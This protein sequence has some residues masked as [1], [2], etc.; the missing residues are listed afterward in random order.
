MEESGQT[1]VTGIQ[2]WF[3]GI[4]SIDILKER[5]VTALIVIGIIFVIGQLTTVV[6][7]FCYGI[8][9]RESGGR[10][11]QFFDRK[12]TILGVVHHELSHALMVL[13]SGAK[14]EGIRLTQRGDTLG[15]VYF[16]PRGNILAR[17]IQYC[18][19]QIGPI[20]F[21]T[22][23]ITILCNLVMSNQDTDYAK[24]WQF[25]VQLI[26]MQQIAYHMQLQG[27]DVKNMMRGVIPQAVIFICLLCMFDFN[28]EWLRIY[29]QAIIYA[30]LLNIA[31]SFILQKLL[32]LFI[33]H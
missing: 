9:C 2:N 27:Q 29:V 28:L 24:T 25:W 20:I 3:I 17:S 30:E 8:V 18:L 19:V 33:R 13:I 21:G 16:R 22:A 7:K 14:L 26:I 10:A 4:T 32:G 5:L 6:R 31:I 1:L 23:S 12:L 11:A 15:A